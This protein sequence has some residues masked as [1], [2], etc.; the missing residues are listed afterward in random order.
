MRPTRYMLAGTHLA[1][2]VNTPEKGANKCIGP[3]SLPS[4]LL[5]GSM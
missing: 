2:V 5:A 4:E 1:C 3:C